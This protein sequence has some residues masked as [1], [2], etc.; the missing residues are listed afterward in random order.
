[1][2]QLLSERSSLHRNLQLDSIVRRINQILFR[3]EVPFGR[4]YGSVPEQ[5]LNLLQFAACCPAHFRAT[6]P[7]IMGGD[8]RYSRGQRVRL[9]QLP[10]DLFAQAVSLSMAGAIHG[11]KN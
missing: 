4:L 6:T 11:A 5:Q 8:S 2:L 9:E 7:Q 1:M 10:D 3:A